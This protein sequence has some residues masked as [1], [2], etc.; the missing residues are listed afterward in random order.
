MEN[1]INELS[2]QIIGAA[3]DVHK[4]LGPGL[5]EKAYHQA[6]MY[7]LKNI[8]LDVKAEVNV[9]YYYKG[10]ELESAYRADI[11]VENKIIVELKSTDNDNPLFAKQLHTYLQLAK[12]DLG[13]LINFNHLVLSHGIKRIVRY[14]AKL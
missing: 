14:G 3:I 9:P 4:E 8:G 11:I 7:E 13:L 10:I 6:M 2:R 12:M 1:S 5:L